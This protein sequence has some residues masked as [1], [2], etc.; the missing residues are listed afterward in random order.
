MNT[1]TLIQYG[2]EKI[3]HLMKETPLLRK[4]SILKLGKPSHTPIKNQVQ[5]SSKEEI[6]NGELRML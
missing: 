6:I 4:I 2:C 5:F 1:Y 3:L